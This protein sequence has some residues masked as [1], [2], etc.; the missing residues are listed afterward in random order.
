MISKKLKRL[1]AAVLSAAMVLSLCAC[2]AQVKEQTESLVSQKKDTPS[3]ES[4]GIQKDKQNQSS[5]VTAR[6]IL[7]DEKT[8]ISGKGASFTQN[9]LTVSE[10][11]TYLIEGKLSDGHILVN[12]TDEQNKV[13]LILSGVEIYCST[14]APIYVES[15]PR[16]TQII[17][18]RGTTSNLSDNASRT[19]TGESGE[20]DAVIY[21][22][23]DLQIQSEE[24]E[25]ND[26]PEGIL[27]VN[28]N[29][30]KGIFSKDD[31]QIKSGTVEIKSADDGIRAKD[32]LEI[33]GGNLTVD[34]GADALR[35]NNTADGKGNIEI[36]GGTLNLT[37]GL[38]AV[39]ATGDISI[40]GGKLT[41]KAG[42]GSTEF[43]TSRPEMIYGTAAE[44]EDT[45]SNKGIK[46]EGEIKIS[47]GSIEIDSAESAVASSDSIEVSG[48]KFI[49]KTNA[50]GF[51]SKNS[52]KV[53]GGSINVKRSYEGIESK[54]IDL[55]GGET[56]INSEDDA[57]NATDS[58]AS[59]QAK[60][61]PAP[62]QGQPHEHPQ[63]S[64]SPNPGATDDYDEDCKIEITGGTHILYASGDGI[65]SNG[66]VEMSGGTVVV[67]GP[68]NGGNG[69]LDFSGKFNFDGG[70][71]LA[72]GSRGMAQKPS[73]GTVVTFDTQISAN[74][75]TV[76]T[77][78]NGKAIIAFN[79][80][81]AYQNVVFA[82][83]ELKE[84]GTYKL[85]SETQH[86]ANAVNGIYSS[87]EYS[88]GRESAKAKAT[89]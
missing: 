26:T 20:A 84:G 54:E 70:R 39:Q 82:S 29:V 67:F 88:G 11:G 37:G 40:S 72:V 19:L 15:S 6:I 44:K 78:E 9:V 53:S 33:S 35:T 47:G 89:D 17:L 5:D 18:S 30:K 41:L 79:S 24:S 86:N 76:I 16:E 52:V 21:S 7:N 56:T 22:K 43:S 13:K 4:T 74:T 61:A 51:H 68:E 49:I 57:L 65:D 42:G 66:D 48:G 38:D 55:S 8:T 34:A 50:D 81:K 58:T 60:E 14:T 63:Q 36:S 69:A 73:S 71:L 1:F 62:P 80:P 45:D 23:D 3:A 31:I 2:S 85:L 83:S 25:T 10:G 28:G 27:V 12:S 75:P 46:A 64:N 77:D 32:L 59:N 87:N